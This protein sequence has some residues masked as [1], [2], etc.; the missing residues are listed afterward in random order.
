MISIHPTEV[1]TYNLLHKWPVIILNNSDALR[2]QETWSS[3]TNGFDKFMTCQQSTQCNGFYGHWWFICWSVYGSGHTVSALSQSPLFIAKKKKDLFVLFISMC[4]RFCLTN[5]TEPKIV[6]I[7][8]LPTC[9]SSV[10]GKYQL[11][12]LYATHPISN[13]SAVS[14]N[15]SAIQHNEG[16][17]GKI[18]KCRQPPEGT[19]SVLALIWRSS[20]VVPPYVR[21]MISTDVFSSFHYSL[22]HR[23][24]KKLK[25]IKSDQLN[26]NLLLRLHIKR[27]TSVNS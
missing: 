18:S 14:H 12:A 11:P 6:G 21:A 1:L 3:F 10:W 5:H 8:V 22:M 2:Q 25:K 20:Y 24:K 26:I 17:W 16:G 23:V 7:E 15:I 27:T 4:C 9:A 19:H 13:S